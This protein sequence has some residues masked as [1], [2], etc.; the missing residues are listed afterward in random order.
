MKSDKE[1]QF[2]LVSYESG[3]FIDY[4]YKMM[5][6][7]SIDYMIPIANITEEKKQLLYF[8]IG[9]KTSLPRL[10]FDSTFAY[11]VIKT[12]IESI[13]AVST[14]INNHLLSL[15]HLDLSPESI[16]YDYSKKHFY[17]I[18]LPINQEKNIRFRKQ[19]FD[20][21][22]YLLDKIDQTDYKAVSLLHR[23]CIIRE[24]EG[25]D[26]EELPKIII[27]VEEAYRI[28]QLE[29]VE[30]DEPDSFFSRIFSRKKPQPA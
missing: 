25:F 4:Q 26:L 15:H 6:K 14:Q 16:Y 18:Y 21:I 11:E 12:L 5:R 9:G 10:L 28:K 30:T 23:L 2:Q 27:E 19:F 24:N 22:H 7:F 8:D 29:A 13:L 1:E 20:L 17:F 3:R